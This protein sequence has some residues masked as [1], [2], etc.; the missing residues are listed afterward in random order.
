MKMYMPFAYEKYGRIEVDADSKEKALKKAEE[1]LDR[2]S[3]SDM[4]ALSDYLQGS[5]EIDDEGIVLDENGNIL[6]D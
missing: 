2:M 3:V 4:E 1:L 6:D 5:Q